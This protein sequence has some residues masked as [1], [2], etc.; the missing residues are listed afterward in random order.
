MREITIDDDAPDL[1]KHDE[2]EAKKK[3]LHCWVML[4]Q[5]EGGV[6]WSLT[7]TFFIE[8]STGW[9]Y[10]MKDCPY[11]TVEAV[12]NNKNFW[13]NLNPE[14]KVSELNM[15][16]EENL[17]WEYIMLTDQDKDEENEDDDEID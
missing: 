14:L 7:E 6:G 16:F 8:P 12:F 13:I 9:K 15:N 2:L 3:W 5:G 1:E 17:E 10:S 4:K 11:Q